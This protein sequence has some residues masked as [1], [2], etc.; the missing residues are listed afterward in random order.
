[1]KKNVYLIIALS[2]IISV[3]LGFY[4]YSIS[5]KNTEI[6]ILKKELVS[7][8]MKPIPSPNKEIEAEKRF[9]DDE[10]FKWVGIKN[11]DVIKITNPI[12]KDIVEVKDIIVISHFDLYGMLYPL[13]YHF[14]PSG[15]TPHIVQ[16][17]IYEFVKDNKTYT[18]SVVR[19][20]LVKI[21]DMYYNINNYIEGLGDAF[22]PPPTYL[23]VKNIFA[24]IYYSGMYKFNK[25][26]YSFDKRH[27][28]LF[29]EY[30]F[31]N[32]LEELKCLPQEV[33]KL[34]STLTF[35]WHKEEII[36]YLYENKNK[37]Q[38]IKLQDNKNTYYFK[39]LDSGY[40]ILNIMGL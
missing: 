22:L 4:L 33:M 34:S 21:D 27:I 8:K 20:D 28:N 1:M 6:N 30:F 11:W 17:Y 2:I 12:T 37:V 3:I 13:T 9:I 7:L 19:D 18:L 40:S 10:N 26:D 35:Y 36:L 39:Q 14:S 16:P 24:K 23:E 31:Q 15:I 32:H 5:C 25:D 38:Y 29:S